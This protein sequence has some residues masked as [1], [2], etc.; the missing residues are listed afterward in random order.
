MS[1]TKGT[2]HFLNRNKYNFPTEIKR[3][4]MMPPLKYIPQTFQTGKHTICNAEVILF[5]QGI[6]HGNKP[7]TKHV[8]NMSAQRTKNQTNTVITAHTY[9]HNT[10]HTHICTADQTAQYSAH[11]EH[12]RKTLSVILTHNICLVR[13]T[14]RT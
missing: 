7:V 14:F 1:F 9:A 13:W 5:L 6:T 2:Q 12:I 4:A 8:E 3:G 11:S 10:V